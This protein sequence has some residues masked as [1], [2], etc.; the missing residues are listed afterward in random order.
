MEEQKQLAT[1][2]SGGL[3]SP[4]KSRSFAAEDINPSDY[5]PDARELA[6][7]VCTRM[8]TWITS[9]PHSSPIEEPHWEKESYGEVHAREFTIWMQLVPKDTTG[10]VK[11]DRELAYFAMNEYCNL[12]AVYGAMRGE[13]EFWGFET[14][15]A[16]T[17]IHVIQWPKSQVAGSTA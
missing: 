12:V 5:G 15:L 10:L 3:R 9:L 1:T 7:K 13:F 16:V 4:S 8:T 11:L 14:V 6:K 17:V 2:P